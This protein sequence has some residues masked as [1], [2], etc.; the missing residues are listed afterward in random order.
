MIIS[1]A[2]ANLHAKRNHAVQ[3]EEFEHPFGGRAVNESLLTRSAEHTEST[4]NP[5]LRHDA[6]TAIDFLRWLD[7]EGRH[8]LCAIHPETRAIEGRS[9][10]PGRWQEME[11]FIEKHRGWNVYF[12]ANEPVTGAPN[13]KLSAT[14]I[15]HLR[16]AFIDCDP[17]KQQEN[18]GQYDEARQIAEGNATR[19][20]A[21]ASALIDS[22]GGFQVMWRL[23]EKLPASADGPA[24]EAQNRGLAM[25]FEADKSVTDVPRILRLPGTVN[26]PDEA[27]RKR[28]RKARQSS[29]QYRYEVDNDADKA[30]LQQLAQIAPPVAAPQKAAGASKAVN[31]SY[32]YVDMKLLKNIKTYD[33]LPRDLIERFEA[34][35]AADRTLQSLWEGK[36]APMQRDE[37]GSGYALALAGSL[38]AARNFTPLD[39]GML[40]K[41]WPDGPDPSKL[42]QRYIG[43]TWLRAPIQPTQLDTTEGFVAMGEDGKPAFEVPWDEPANLWAE[44]SKP[45]ELPHGVLPEIVELLARDKGRRLGVEPGAVAAV[46]ITALGSLVPARNRL[47]MRQFNTGWTVHPVLWAAI[48]GSSGKNKSATLTYGVKAA[49]HVENKW[50]AGHQEAKRRAEGLEKVAPKGANKLPTM[51]E[52]LFE[53][54]SETQ[55]GQ[56]PAPTRPRRRKIVRDATTEAIGLL[57]GNNPDGLLYFSEELAGWLGSMDAY[58][59]RGGKDR[60]FWLQAK[61]GGPYTIDRKTSGDIDIP[62]LAVSVLGGIQPDKV[63]PL[64]ASLANDGLLQR[65]MPILLD[66]RGR[67]VDEAPD[68]GL[69]EDGARLA[70]SLAEAERDQLFK[71]APDAAAELKALEDFKDREIDRPNT[72][73][74]FQQWLD[75]LPNEF[76][77]VALVFH[78]VEHHTPRSGK[79]EEPT[80]DLISKETA[81]RARRFLTEYVFSHAQA[82]YS[83]V[84]GQSAMDEHSTW[85][86]GYFLARERETVGEREL[87]RA[88]G[89]FK[90]TRGGRADLQLAMETLDMQGWVRPIGYGK[91]GATKWSVN[92]AVHDGR[93]RER[94]HIER[95]RRAE[96]RSA[97]AGTGAEH[98]EAA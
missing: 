83:R 86:A 53:G 59:P 6:Q 13:K 5:I 81:R 33:D 18:E 54:A 58:R 26:W 57:L 66:R 32:P 61:D 55:I 52:E 91:R 34:R 88:Y 60:P 49:E 36:R 37:T 87:Y 89:P 8:N 2:E 30:T 97:I 1:D 64:A 51:A 69:E 17:P 38:K 63:K 27:K 80:P 23:R 96:V 19:A 82:F 71:F 20:F 39:F 16:V 44:T 31:E 12:S 77:R 9:F 78:F 73:S 25:L 7:P 10:G 70:V 95:A 90:E 94:A 29:V 62:A 68:A 4:P 72:S 22:G 92:P 43:R 45:A 11:A 15:S 47:Q 56:A 14:E 76:G 3:V 24:S 93:F 40:L 74:A 28:G 46:L 21:G 75:K 84:L 98:R 79:A 50:R 67:G 42:D 41:V 85:V 48:I 65:F 35:S